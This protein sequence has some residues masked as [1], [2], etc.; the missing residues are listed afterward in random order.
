M[1]RKDLLGEISH[2][3]GGYADFAQNDPR[4]KETP[5]RLLFQ[6]DGDLDMQRI[7][8]MGTM[9]FLSTPP[10]SEGKTSPRCC[11]IGLAANSY[12]P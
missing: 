3:V 12:S 7:G 4:T 6:I 5:L 2:Q 9:Q 10:T 11:W 1:P 8:D